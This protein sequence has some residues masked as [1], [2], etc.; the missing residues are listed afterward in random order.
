MI[1]SDLILILIC[2]LGAGFFDGME[3]GVISLNRMRLRHLA[4]TG[5]RAARILQN[6]LQQP[7]RLLGTT[8]V[9]TNIC[10]VIASV[11]SANWS[12]QMHPWL[13][14][15]NAI[16][17]TLVILIFATYLPKAW[18]QSHPLERCR[19]FAN[20]LRWSSLI[21]RPLINSANWITNWIVPSAT[22]P[23]ATRA[24]VATK[25]E[26]DL[27]AQESADHGALSP[28]QR[29]M[30]R[31]VLELST[32]NARHIMTPRDQMAILP[33]SADI[34]ALMLKVRECAHTRL[35]VCEEDGKTIKGTINFF[36]VM[37]GCDDCFGGSIK[38]YIR[39]ALFVQD[40][41]PLMEAFAKLRLSKQSMCLVV[42]STQEVIGL[43]TNQNVLQTIVGKT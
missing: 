15:L 32:K 37:A 26:I 34:T 28:R 42:N 38:P 43:I 11:I 31:R 33:S 3:T 19:P 41:T 4:E 35:P 16:A 7:D 40:T 22:A 30:I 2:L 12:S 13:Q 20:P 29:I 14:T 25:D 1:F 9:G 6:F 21:L 10:I 17:T 8:L 24:L 39:P 27:L 5:D 23:K 18:F 36:D